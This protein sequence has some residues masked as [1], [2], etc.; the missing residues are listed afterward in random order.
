MGVQRGRND[1]VSNLQ[2]PHYTNFILRLFQ[3][4]VLNVGIIFINFVPRDAPLTS[5][6]NRIPLRKQSATYHK[7]I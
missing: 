2:N 4:S 3:C 7:D 6:E 5:P 1:D